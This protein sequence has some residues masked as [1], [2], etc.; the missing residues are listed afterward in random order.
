MDPTAAEPVTAEVDGWT[1][2]SSSMNRPTETELKESLDGTPPPDGETPVETPPVEPAAPETPVVDPAA[3]VAPKP[4]GVAPELQARIDKSVRAQREAER[5]RDAA[6]YRTEQL[7]REI[8]T[9][10]SAPPPVVP[11][12]PAPSAADPAAVPPTAPVAAAPPAGAPEPLWADFEAKGESWEDYQ[13]A[14]RTWNHQTTVAAATAAAQA[15]VKERLEVAQRE[16]AATRH[17]RDTESRFQARLDLMRAKNPDYD[18]LVAANGNTLDALNS[19]YLEHLILYTNDG[20]E[21]LLD[22]VRDPAAAAVLAEQK[23]TRAIVDAIG[24]SDNPRALLGYFAQHP[25]EMQRLNAATDARAVFMTLGSLTARL[26]GAPS[27]AS[28][29]VVPATPLRPSPP[30]RPVAGVSTTAGAAASPDDVPFGPE[31]VRLG[32]RADTERRRGL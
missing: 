24:L 31:Y 8:A 13:Q 30:L 10:R 26:T 4:K 25:E 9:L 15:T 29:G 32:N 14:W 11:V 2:Q 18:E 12:A 5:D 21:I 3:P 6:R 20:A 7:E 27:A 28:P 22:I 19:A 23:P 16:E 17:Q 1:V